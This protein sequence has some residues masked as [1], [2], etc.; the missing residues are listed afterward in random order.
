[1]ISPHVIRKLTCCRAGNVAVNGSSIKE[2]EFKSNG[3]GDAIFGGV[4]GSV[5]IL[6]RGAGN[7][8]ILGS[9]NFLLP[10]QNISS[11]LVSFQIA[12][13][14]SSI[15]K[16]NKASKTCCADPCVQQT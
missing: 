6:M 16:S 5:K 1:M 2:L 4:T 14:R 9:G 7:L 10:L 13:E 3:A 11:S 8:K 12:W 15:D